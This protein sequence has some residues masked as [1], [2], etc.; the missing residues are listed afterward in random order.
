MTW[1]YTI[2]VR[3]N[4]LWNNSNRKLYDLWPISRVSSI[5]LIE[6]YAGLSCSIHTR[7]TD[8]FSS[9]IGNEEMTEKAIS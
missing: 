4:T 7:S 3:D 5:H 8:E 1:H 2:I 6:F 9:E